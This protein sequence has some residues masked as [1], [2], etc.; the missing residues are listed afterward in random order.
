MVSG[1]SNT[2]IGMYSGYA[3]TGS[4]NVFIGNGAGWNETGSSRLYI[5]NSSTSSPLIWGDFSGNTV[6]INGN[7]QYTGTITDVSDARYKENVE[8]IN[9]ALEKLSLLRGVYFDWNSF[10]DSTLVVNGDRQIGVI[11]QEVESVFPE[12]VITNEDGYKMVDYTKLAPILIEAVKSQQGQI[13]LIENEN[14]S[15]KENNTLLTNEIEELKKLRSRIEQL[16][17]MLL[18]TAEK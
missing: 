15:L 11:A 16:E 14:K 17:M 7:L 9:N 13:A 6:R 10:A 4:S 18:N 12:L 3:A 1:S 8:T 5:D 2:F